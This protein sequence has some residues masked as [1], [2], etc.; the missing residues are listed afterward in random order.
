MAQH[1]ATRDSASATAERDPVCFNG[2]T[3]RNV[4][5]LAYLPPTQNP[6]TNLR[7][8]GNVV[9]TPPF[10]TQV[11]FQANPFGGSGSFAVL[12]A[13]MTGPIQTGVQNLTQT[14]QWYYDFNAPN[15][16]PPN[17]QA[18]T[19]N[20]QLF[21]TLNSPQGPAITFQNPPVGGVYIIP[22]SVTAK[23]MDWA[24]SIGWNAIQSFSIGNV[25]YCPNGYP[26]GADYDYHRRRKI[27]V[28]NC[29]NPRLEGYRTRNGNQRRSLAV[30]GQKPTGGLYYT[31]D[32]GNRRVEHGW[33][34]SRPCRAFP[35][36][37]G[38]GTLDGSG[39]LIG[40]SKVLSISATSGPP[41]CTPIT[42]TTFTYNG[43]AGF[44]ARLL[45]P[46]S[47]E[48]EGF[49]TVQDPTGHTKAYTVYPPN[50]PAHPF[51]HSTIRTTI[52]SRP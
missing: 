39:A 27:H 1:N 22:G 32:A 3:T 26:K 8:V 18:N 12:Q 4:S 2:N 44:K 50:S 14:F 48:F 25:T 19:T 40:N 15:P 6:P 24:T 29:A 42:R 28:C 16:T 41:T 49:F 35:T 23:R 20:H 47:Q 51:R 30:P 13:N 31:G 37:D 7:I 33:S 43:V 10:G 45:Y 34:T 21:V 5:V 52:S 9:A 11:M 36:A 46:T 38:S 17:L